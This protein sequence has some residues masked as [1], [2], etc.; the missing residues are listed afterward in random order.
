MKTNAIFSLDLPTL[1]QLNEL[2]AKTETS[3]SAL[4]RQ[5]LR[6]F[7]NKQRTVTNSETAVVVDRLLS[8]IRVTPNAK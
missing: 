5:A 1:V 3:K 8:G 4:V 2:S 6:E 7:L